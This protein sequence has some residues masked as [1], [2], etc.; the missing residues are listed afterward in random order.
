[1]A[2]DHSPTSLRSSTEAKEEDGHGQVVAFG[3]DKRRSALDPSDHWNG[4]CEAPWISPNPHEAREPV[5]SATVREPV[6]SAL[7]NY[8]SI[9]SFI[10]LVRSLAVRIILL[11]DGY[12]RRSLLCC[13]RT[14]FI[15]RYDEER[16]LYIDGVIESNHHRLLPIVN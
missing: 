1:M 12:L 8:L 3:A 15:P 9:I 14:L 10:A 16:I 7:S 13:W 4:L 2:R 6:R 5:Q 11:C